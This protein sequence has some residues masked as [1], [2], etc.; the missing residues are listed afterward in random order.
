MQRAH[1]TI[2]L[3]IAVAIGIGSTPADLGRQAVPT[4]RLDGVWAIWR[5][6]HDGRDD[7]AQRRAPMTLAHGVVTFKPNVVVND[8]LG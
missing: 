3:L 1:L 5:V 7:P 8:A 6:E 2:V 4:E